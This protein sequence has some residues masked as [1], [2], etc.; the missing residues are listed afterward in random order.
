MFQDALC[1]LADR[2]PF[3][4]SQHLV[5]N[6]AVHYMADHCKHETQPC[7]Q[8]MVVAHTLLHVSGHTWL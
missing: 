7:I 6:D 4:S 8:S 3:P 1:G 5:H 2:L